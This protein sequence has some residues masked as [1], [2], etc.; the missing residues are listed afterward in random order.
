VVGCPKG[1]Q[2]EFMN[3]VIEVALLFGNL[4]LAWGKTVIWRGARRL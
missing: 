2:V 4:D 1:H 3:K